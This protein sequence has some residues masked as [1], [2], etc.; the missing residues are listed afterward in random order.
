MFRTICEP[1]ARK[2]LYPISLPQGL[3]LEADIAKMVRTACN[4]LKTRSLP[5]MFFDNRRYYTLKKQFRRKQEITFLNL[6]S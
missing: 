3:Y 2:W 1:E 6:I 5:K 4:V